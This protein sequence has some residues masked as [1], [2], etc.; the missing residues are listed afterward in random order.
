MKRLAM[1]VRA[2]AETILLEIAKAPLAYS[3]PF[4]RYGL[5]QQFRERE[6]SHSGTKYRVFY[7]IEPGNRVLIYQVASFQAG[8]S[9]LD[10][11]GGR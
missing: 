8:Y 9:G 10:Q 11:R 6:F 2:H 4:H 3:K 5:P 7:T 1:P